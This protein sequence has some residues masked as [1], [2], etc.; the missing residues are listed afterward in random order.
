MSV[1]W[2]VREGHVVHF[3]ADSDGGSYLQMKD[4]NERIPIDFV[5]QKY[6][7][8]L[9][10]NDRLDVVSLKQKMAINLETQIK[11]AHLS[12]RILEETKRRNIVRNF[13][14]MLKH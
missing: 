10:K 9:T 6:F 5:D 4:S 2:A 13:S 1:P 11:Y 12:G 8:I 3:A 7:R 14:K